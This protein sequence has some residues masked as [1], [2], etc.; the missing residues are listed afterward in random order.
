MGQKILTGVKATG[1][2]HLGNYVG[3]IKP[4]L[5]LAQKD[6]ISAYLFIA[7]SHS[8]TSGPSSEELR[9]SIYKVAAVWLACGLDFEKTVFYR[10]SDIPELFELSW[11]L[12]CVTPKGLMNRAHSYKSK[13]NQN[14]QAGKKDL[15]DGINMGLYNYPILMA[16]D[17]LL[18]SPNLVPVGQDQ[19]QHLEMIRD[20]AQK[21]NR[22]YKME[23]FVIPE[24]LVRKE[25]VLPGLDGRKMS[26]SYN[27]EIPLF[28]E[29]KK[30]HK[31]IRK[32]KTDSTPAEEPKDPKNCL[33]FEMFRHFA[34]EEEIQ[35][36]KE[37]YAGGIGWAE[38]KDILFEKLKDYFKNK[39]EIYDH[40]I[41]QPL[42]L[43][44]ILERGSERARDEA[45]VFLREIKK[46][47]GFRHHN[48]KS[49]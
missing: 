6:N 30:L 13:R 29:S 26:K 39:K 34:C 7:D 19:L 48:K 38:V 21:F 1:E 36:L 37:R 22:I 15:D 40:Y 9:D 12:S 11:I 23:F 4:S 2:P 10:Q 18:F 31:L 20:I 33:I 3:A 24:A 27:N 49:V 35:S 45:Q 8:L 41:N 25:A 46:N 28:L 47:I 32:I 14:V 5:D 43:E 42:E 16:A 44:K 17:V